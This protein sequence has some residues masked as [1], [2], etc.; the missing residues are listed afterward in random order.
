MAYLG[1]YFGLQPCGD[2]IFESMVLSCYTWGID[3][4]GKA[5][6]GRVDSFQCYRHVTDGSTPYSRRDWIIGMWCGVISNK[7]AFFVAWVSRGSK[8]IQ[9]TAPASEQ[10]GGISKDWR[11][12]TFKQ[13][14]TICIIVVMVMLRYCNPLQ[15]L[16]LSKLC[17]YGTFILY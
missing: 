16:V 3:C 8:L 5:R 4:L 2:H 13:I 17:W 6:A 15:R 10:N 11:P 1:F 14:V 12:F 9:F 7:R